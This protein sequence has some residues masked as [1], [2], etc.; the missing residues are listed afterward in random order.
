MESVVWLEREE[1]GA[2]DKERSRV[3]RPRVAGELSRPTARKQNQTCSEGEVYGEGTEKVHGAKKP[4]GSVEGSNM[5]H[6]GRKIFFKAIK[7]DTMGLG[8]QVRGN[9]TTSGA[10]LPEGSIGRTGRRA[11]GQGAARM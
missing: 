3:A 8:E 5:A 2:K 11:A 10:L 4:E 1:G 6:T 7:L 9:Q